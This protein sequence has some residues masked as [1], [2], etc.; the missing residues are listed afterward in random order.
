MEDPSEIGRLMDATAYKG[1][2]NE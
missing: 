2:L 1:T